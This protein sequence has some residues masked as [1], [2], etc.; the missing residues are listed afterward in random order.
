MTNIRVNNMTDPDHIKSMLTKTIRNGKPASIIKIGGSDCDSF[1]RNVL[2]P[3]IYELTDYFDK[4][5]NGVDEECNFKKMRE[6]Y[7]K[8]LRNGDMITICNEDRKLEFTKEEELF[9]GENVKG[10]VP[11]YQWDFANFENENNFFLNIFPIL[12]DKKIC[13]ISSFIDDIQEQLK[14]KDKLFVNQCCNDRVGFVY[15]NFTYPTFKE[16]E[17]VKVPLCQ[18]KYVDIEF[19]NSLELLVHLKTQITRTNSDIYLIGAGLYSNL[20]CDFAKEKGK[21]AINC[22]SAIQLFFGL[23]ENRFIHLEK[24]NVTNEYWKYLDIS[25]CSDHKNIEGYS[26]DD[27]IV[28]GGF[29]CAT[30]TLKN[31]FSIQKTH[32]SIVDLKTHNPTTYSKKKVIVFPFRNNE[33][34]YPSAFFQDIIIHDYPYSPFHKGNFLDLY[35]NEPLSTKTQIIN[36]IDVKILVNFYNTQKWDEFGYLNSIF[37]INQTNQVFNININYDSDEVQIF[38]VDGEKK[39]IAFNINILEKNFLKISYA[40]WGV[41]NFNFKYESFNVG[42]AKWY[43]DKYE[44]FVK[45]LGSCNQN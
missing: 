45:C 21:I 43:K 37:R 6:F 35:I 33:D 38:M 29:K 4:S 18:T 8:S 7:V 5:T 2:N 23:M 20:L 41:N 42:S 34:T 13:I 24:Q 44:E 40:I 9:F 28:C 39:L 36:D 19:Q 30:T 1:I 27:I 3:N 16:V 12:N 10:Q 17:Y 32:N 25:K 11:I 15:K 26:N 31:I 14:I 22:G